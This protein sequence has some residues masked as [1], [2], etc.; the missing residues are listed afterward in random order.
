MI[1]SGGFSLMANE[2]AAITVTEIV[3]VYKDLSADLYAALD[4]PPTP[5]DSREVR[6]RKWRK[7][8]SNLEQMLKQFR[9]GHLVPVVHGHSLGEISRACRDIRALIARPTVIALG[10]MVPFLRGLMGSQFLYRQA[11]GSLGASD[12]FVADALLACREEFPSSHLHV[13]GAGST[14]TAFALLALGTHSVDSLSWRRAAGFGTIFLAGYPERIVSHERR[15][16]ESRPRIGAKDYSVLNECKCPIC[17]DL[18][19]IKSKLNAL[20]KSYVFRAVHNVWTLQTEE[21]ALRTAIAC[22]TLA[23]FASS[24]ISQRH[25]FAKVV[26]ERLTT[27]EAALRGS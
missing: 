6:R 25:R 23:D 20:G 10:G 19:D 26:R 24:R 21:A 2:Q 7:T 11:N 27:G 14:T 17:I 1:D 15:I 9:D 22:C 3:S 18:K 4:V 5:L 8:L 13:F 16:L 12:T